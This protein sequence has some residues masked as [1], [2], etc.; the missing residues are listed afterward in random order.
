MRAVILILIP[1]PLPKEVLQTSSCKVY[2]PADTPDLY[3]VLVVVI[4][5]VV[6][7]VV[8]VRVPRPFLRAAKPLLR[9]DSV[10]GAFPSIRDGPDGNRLGMLSYPILSYPILSY[11][12]LHYTI[13]YYTIL[14]YTI[15]YYNIIYYTILFYTILFYT[16]LYHNRIH[17]TFRDS[18][19]PESL[20]AVPFLR[21]EMTRTAIALVARTTLGGGIPEFQGP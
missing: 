20:V 5:V 17:Y 8:P 15:L 6:V 18:N 14:Y 7:V 4:V 9:A 1:I 3:A 10:A 12:I 11:P 16:I 21:F 2:V 13:L 19:F